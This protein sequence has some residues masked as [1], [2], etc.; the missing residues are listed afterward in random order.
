MEIMVI[1][2]MGTLGLLLAE[3]YDYVRVEQSAS[4]EGHGPTG[5]RAARTQESYAWPLSLAGA[6][7]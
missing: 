1:S 3:L 4:R 6:A 5:G 7:R 2:V